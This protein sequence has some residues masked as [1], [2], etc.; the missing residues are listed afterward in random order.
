[1][2]WFS[3]EGEKEKDK[4][5]GKEETTSSE[6]QTLPEEDVLEPELP[7]EEESQMSS[8]ED[9]SKLYQ[10]FLKEKDAALEELTLLVSSLQSQMMAG[11]CAV[12]GGC[13]WRRNGRRCSWDWLKRRI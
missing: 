5:E 2:R 4:E 9:V 7:E 3:T 1:M 13:S 12:M 6:G 10:A 11:W 8:K